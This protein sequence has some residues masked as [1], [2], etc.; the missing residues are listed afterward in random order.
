MILEKFIND[1]IKKLSPYNP[2]DP[3]KK[4]SE[5]F[6]LDPGKII[7]LN[8]NENPFGPLEEV[9]D[10]MDEIPVNIYPDPNQD[11]L[12]DKLSLYTGAS[13]K[14]IIAGSGAD[15]LIEIIFKLFCKKGDTLVDIEPTFGM[16]SFLAESIGMNVVKLQSNEDWDF[17]LERIKQIIDENNVTVLFLASPNNPTGNLV[18]YHKLISLLAMDLI[19]VV[20]ETYYEFS[21]TSSVDLL[22]EYR[23]LIILRSF[24]KWAGLAGLR[25]GY[26]VANE[27]IINTVFKVKQPYNVNVVAERAAI[28]TLTNPEPLLENIKIIIDERN[29][30]DQFLNNLPDATP[31]PSNGNFILCKFAK[32]SNDFIFNKLARE[33]IFVRSFSEEILKDCLRFTIGTPTQMSKV[34]KELEKIFKEG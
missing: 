5:M 8:A 24:S 22:K 4:F 21:N 19:V 1:H 6:N 25:G 2:V 13:K 14:N 27:E 16:Y 17:D 30:F 10:F 7:R 33:G 11:E 29:K 28:L 9:Y 26:M 20:D 31:F 3:N 18:E 34:Q 15:E 32:K 12:R 23:N